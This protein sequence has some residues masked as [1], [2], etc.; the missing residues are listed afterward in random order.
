M[1]FIYCKRPIGEAVSTINLVCNILVKI[2]NHKQ[3]MFIQYIHYFLD[4]MEIPFSFR[5]KLV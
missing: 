2:N 1:K 5:Q 4:K 3:T